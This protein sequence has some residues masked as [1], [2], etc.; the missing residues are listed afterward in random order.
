MKERLAKGQVGYNGLDAAC[1][2]HDIAYDKYLKGPERRE[3]D[4]K[5]AD[6]AWQRFKAKDSSI[7]E[8]AA[9]LTVT[10]IMRAKS[11]LGLGLRKTKKQ[12]KKYKTKSK[13]SPLQAA[14]QNA[15]K[16]LLRKKPKS[17]DKAIK[18]ALN[19]ARVSIKNKNYKGDKSVKP[20]I[21]PLPKKIG[22]GLPILAILAGLSAV[23][24]LLGGAGSV[25][26][27]VNSAKSAEKTLNEATRHNEMM[28]AIALGKDKKG[29]GLYLQPYKKG[30]ALFLDNRKK[31]NFV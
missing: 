19:A 20:R 13:Q 9:A 15:K 23:G 12:S 5:L 10:G 21:I 14:I 17:M 28:E 31:S 16:A 4:K 6:A 26:K 22:S 3:A 11:K 27:A 2:V 29:N 18:L 25:A 30:M 7:G 1:R 24:S 8:K